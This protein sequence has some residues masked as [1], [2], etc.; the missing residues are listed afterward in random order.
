MLMVGE[1]VEFSTPRLLFAPEAL[2]VTLCMVGEVATF[3]TAV[4]W[5]ADPE[6]YTDRDVGHGF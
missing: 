4:F 3:C 1:D 2:A 6:A 5:A